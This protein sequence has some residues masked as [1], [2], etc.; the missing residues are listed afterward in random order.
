MSQTA[1]RQDKGSVKETL[2]SITI[3]LVVAFVFRAFVIEAFVIPTGS[4]APTLMG[5]HM[6]FRSPQ[7]GYEW[8]VN[9]W[10]DVRLASGMTTPARVQTGIKVTDPMS[11]AEIRRDAEPLRSGDRILVLKYLTGVFDPQRFDCFVFKAPHEPQVNYIKRL[12]GLPGEQ[13]ALV[14]GDVFVREVAAQDVEEDDGR[15]WSR[16]GWRIARKPERVQRAVWQDVFSSE[17]QPLRPVRDDRAWFRSPWVG[18]RGQWQIEGRRSYRL[19]GSGAAVLEWDTERWPIGDRYPYNEVQSPRGPLLQTPGPGMF[20]SL[21]V[22][23]ATPVYPVSDLRMAAGIEP[24]REGGTVAAIIRARGHEFRGIIEG[25]A[26][27]VDMRPIPTRDAETPWIM[28]DQ[29]T[30]SRPL[31]AGRVT[32]VEFWHVDQSL[33]LR[34]DGRIV[35][36]GEY[37]WSPTERIVHSTGRTIEWILAESASTG[38]HVLGETRTY[39][40]SLARPRWE[41][42]A[43]GLTMHRVGI[44]RDVYYQ[45]SNARGDVL[46]AASP[47]RTPRLTSRHD[48]P[49][50]FDQFLACGDNSPASSDSRMWDV[51]DP[52]VGEQ[53][54]TTI[55]IVPQRL[56]IGKAFGVYFP[57]LLKSRP[58]PMVDFGRVRWIW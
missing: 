29:A 3:A 5:Q 33:T 9:P 43:G 36:K 23:P 30:L 24:D 53:I 12:I 39:A 4:M 40:P 47:T 34:I 2:I 22:S 10:H 49:N 25:N 1:H 58:V 18:S 35:A 42:D 32:N 27:R 20:T 19:E 16:D 52:W 31:Q 56:V 45:P 15:A 41:F 48:G 38:R 14:D 17:Y 8:A 51:V 11:G 37:N 28:L 54:D 7:T 50:A 13:V 57:S 46:L 6:R 26:A 55:G 21:P 44:S